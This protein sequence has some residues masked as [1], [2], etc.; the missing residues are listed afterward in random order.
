MKG[1][2]TLKPRNKSRTWKIEKNRR[3]TKASNL[4][5]NRKLENSENKEESTNYKNLK[6]STCKKM[7]I[8]RIKDTFKMG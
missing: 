6:T 1:D 5:A 8:K 4:K 2:K 3:I 7:K